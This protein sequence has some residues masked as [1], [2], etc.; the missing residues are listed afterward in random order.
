MLGCAFS[1]MR[2]TCVDASLTKK[3]VERVLYVLVVFK[4]VDHDSLFFNRLFTFLFN[5]I[6]NIKM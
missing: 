3:E 6:T 4:F 5:F 2:D 1:R